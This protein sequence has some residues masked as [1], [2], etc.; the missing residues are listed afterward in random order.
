MALHRFHQLDPRHEGPL[1]GLEIDKHLRTSLCDKVAGLLAVTKCMVSSLGKSTCVR[2]SVAYTQ[3]AV[4]DED[5]FDPV[6]YVNQSTVAGKL[7]SKQHVIAGQHGCRP[8]CARV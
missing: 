3:Q 8:A 6:P 5:I 4:C 1:A 2:T 7:S